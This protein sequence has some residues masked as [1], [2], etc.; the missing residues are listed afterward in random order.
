MTRPRDRALRVAASAGWLLLVLPAAVVL[1]SVALSPDTPWTARIE[2]AAFTVVA[3][4]R[5]EAAVLM[6]I[7]LG[8]FNIILIFLRRRSIL[9]V[10][11]GTVVASLAGCFARAGPP[12]SPYRRALTS[13]LSVPAVLFAT[14]TVA[15]A[16]VW[17]RVYQFR[18]GDASA[19]FAELVKFMTRDYFTQ[20]GDFF[21]CAGRRRRLTLGE[22]AKDVP[23]AALSRGQCH[24]LRAGAPNA[25][26]RRSRPRDDERGSP[27]GS[28]AAEPGGD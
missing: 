26:G 4:I 28:H 27:F 22:P 10:T 18:T 11:E 13:S 12:D 15:S 8:G 2:L 14:T 23:A 16:I 7:A 25:G 5:P 21:W 19:Y 24:I 17:Q 6:T 20:P 1:L 3:V 9:R